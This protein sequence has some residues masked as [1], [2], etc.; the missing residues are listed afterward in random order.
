VV[1]QSAT[2]AAAAVSAVKAAEKK[3]KKMRKAS[4]PPVVETPTI[5]TPQTREVESEEEEEEDEATDEPPVVE[6]RPARRSLSPATKRQQELTQKTTKDALHQSL[7]VQ[8][9][10]AAAQE[11][12]HVLIRPQFFRTKP[13]VPAITR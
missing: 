4:P 11:K 7:E 1:K 12:M 10:A 8:R 3:K 9:T 2:T 6:D 5:P 13:R